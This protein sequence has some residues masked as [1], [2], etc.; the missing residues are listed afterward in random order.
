ML[1]CTIYACSMDEAIRKK[2]A[3]FTLV[4]LQA[5]LYRIEY[6]QTPVHTHILLTQTHNNFYHI[7]TVQSH[8]PFILPVLRVTGSK[9]WFPPHNSLH[10]A[11]LPALNCQD[12]L[13]QSRGE[14]PGSLNG[15]SSARQEKQGRGVWCV[16]VEGDNRYF[17]PGK[18]TDTSAVSLSYLDQCQV[19]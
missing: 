10:N 12:N 2:K 1:S 7:I 8:T 6:M 5:R 4:K 15:Y 11:I 17:P 14:S 16:C 19:V 13:Y 9:I 18:A 3:L